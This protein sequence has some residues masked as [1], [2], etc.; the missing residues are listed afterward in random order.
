M[1]T[2]TTKSN[3]DDDFIFCCQYAWQEGQTHNSLLEAK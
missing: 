2:G 1:D 3:Q